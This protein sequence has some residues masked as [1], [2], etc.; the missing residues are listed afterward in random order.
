MK[1]TNKN[2]KMSWVSSACKTE[3]KKDIREFLTRVGDKWSIL[4]VVIL[5]KFPQRR[6]R[7]SE[8]QQIVDGISRR[9]LTTTL[10]HL[11]RD[12][13]VTR[14][15]YPQVPPRVEY[16]LTPLGVSLLEPMEHLMRWVETNWPK[17]KS[18]RQKFK[19]DL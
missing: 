13:F 9:M 11:E 6:A 17:V 15:I 19:G 2:Q 4:L 3:D 14:Q 12:G 1:E 8:L 16:T 7:F 10:R 5:S 18:S